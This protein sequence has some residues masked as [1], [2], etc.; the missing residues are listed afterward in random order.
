MNE[1]AELG[2]VKDDLL[3]NKGLDVLALA[4]GLIWARHRVWLDYDGFGFGVPEGCRPEQV[5]TFGDEQYNSEVIWEQIDRGQTAGIFQIGT[6]SGTKQAMRFKP[7]SLV[8]LA[9]L[10]GK[11]KLPDGVPVESLIVY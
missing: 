11:G 10:G 7:R 4:R 6:A 1:V 2:G 9:D 5:V 3:A 8:E